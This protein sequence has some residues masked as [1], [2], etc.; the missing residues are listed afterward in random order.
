MRIT[1]IPS[2]NTIIVDR[3][4][5]RPTEATYPQGVKAIQWYGEEGYIEYREGPQ[6]HFTE[7]EEMEPFVALHAAAKL[8][9]ETPPPGPP[10]PPAKTLQDFKAE[11]RLKI[12]EWRQIANFT[13]THQGKEFACDLLS[14]KDIVGTMGS[15][16]LLGEFPPGWPGGWKAIDNTY[17]P[18]TTREQFE[19]FYR[20]MCARGAANFAHSQV[21]KDAVAAATTP[22][23]LDAIVW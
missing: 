8:R 5:R 2:D 21:L 22:E 19:D 11:K 7:F 12:N 16:T 6:T 13:F 17:L 10:A 20:S 14:D 9:D 3:D 23:A 18:I 15:L 4:A 1:V